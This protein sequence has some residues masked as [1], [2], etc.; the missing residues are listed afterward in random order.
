MYTV[1]VFARDSITW[2]V[3]CD[4]DAVRWQTHKREALRRALAQLSER[5]LL[6][7]FL[8][9]RHRAALL[10]SRYFPQISR[11]LCE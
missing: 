8:A 5:R 7:D 6:A 1:L 3:C 11:G 4:Q 10:K 2:S 9:W